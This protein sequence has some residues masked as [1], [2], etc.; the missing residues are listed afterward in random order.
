MIL[1]IIIVLIILIFLTFNIKI[2]TKNF[3]IEFSKNSL[4]SISEDSKILLK[5]YLLFFFK[6]AQIDLIKM[7][8]NKK[9]KDKI[10]NKIS[11]KKIKNVGSSLQHIDKLRYAL[12]KLDLKI[13]IG[14]ED[15][16][17]T[18]IIIG[19]VSIILSFFMAKIVKDFNN[20]KY[21]IN[22]LYNSNILK[23]KLDCVI[24]FN[25]IDVVSVTKI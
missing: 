17:F 21:E 3:Q 11:L 6:I 25:I 20:K 15:P 23:I 2:E 13:G 1:I 14:I 9:I 8:K 10:R 5:I 4:Y 7:F 16:A 19:Y 24:S 12:E 22:P 18:A